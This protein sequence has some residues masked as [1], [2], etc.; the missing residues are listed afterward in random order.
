[1]G[2]DIPDCYDSPFFFDYFEI[3]YDETDLCSEIDEYYEEDD[4]VLDFYKKYLQIDEQRIKELYH[5]TF[6]I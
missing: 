4:N 2:Y 6:T 3:E 5:A 1:M